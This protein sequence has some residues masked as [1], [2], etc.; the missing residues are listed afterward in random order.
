[1]PGIIED[2][3]DVENAPKPQAN[4]NLPPVPPKGRAVQPW[5]RPLQEGPD[6]L[7]NQTT[8]PHVI[9]HEKPWHRRAQ[10][11]SMQG[12]TNIEIAAMLGKTDVSVATV[13]KQSWVIERMND[14]MKE[15]A[16]TQIKAFL[17]AEC[18]P[19]LQRIQKV[20]MGEA[21][22]AKVSDQN[23]ANFYLADRFLGKAPQIISTVSAKP[24]TE[25]TNDELNTQVQGIVAGMATA[26]EDAKEP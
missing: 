4:S 1:M 15:D 2:W 24:V 3:R 10:E 19:S 13:L 18:L 17:E 11:L 8:A 22:G 16:S 9:Q 21:L 25:L 6:A 5:S 14:R 26:S 12:Y 7:F 23:A 20:A